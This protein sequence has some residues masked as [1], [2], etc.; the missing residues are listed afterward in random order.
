MGP[1]TV[2]TGGIVMGNKGE[3]DIIVKNGLKRRK[4]F[5]FNQFLK[6]FTCVI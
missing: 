6:A 5:A 1:K 4:L 2:L 3:P